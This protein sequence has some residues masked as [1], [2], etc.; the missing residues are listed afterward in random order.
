MTKEQ[1]IIMGVTIDIVVVVVPISVLCC[2]LWRTR[3]FRGN[4]A[5]SED[6]GTQSTQSVMCQLKTD[7]AI[8][9]KSNNGRE[10]YELPLFTLSSIQIATSYFSVANKIGEGGFGHV[11]KGQLVNGQEIAVKRLSRSSQQGSEEFRNEVILISRLQHRNLVR[12]LGCCTQ[13]D[14]RI[15]IYEYLP[16]KSLDSFLFD[17]TKRA[18][19][20]W[21][22]RVHIIE[23]I[24]QGLQ[25]LHKHSRVRIIHKDLKASN[26]LLDNDMNP[27]ISDFGTARIF[28]DNES[29]ASTKRIV[30]T[31]GYMSP[32]YALYGRFSMKSDVFSFGVMMLEIISGKRNTDFY[33]PDRASNLLGYAWDLWK[34]GRGLE[35]MDHSLVETCSM[36]DI[37]RYIQIGFLC[38]QESAVDRPTISTVLSMLSNEMVAILAPKQPAFFAIVSLNDAYTDEISKPCSINEVTI[39][40]VVSR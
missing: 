7:A 29:R 3:C 23:G 13:G 25:Y 28:G 17:E 8:I 34:D 12:I 30:G 39:S 27:K 19:L 1:W 21:K 24:A 33:M 9:D 38:V 40:E 10:D 4:N 14:E 32:E 11:Y 18:L 15:L 31:Y 36:S 5:I 22:I 2:Y 37:M 16:N 26:I 20:D 6:E 35:I